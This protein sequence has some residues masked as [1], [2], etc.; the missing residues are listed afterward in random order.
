MK[1]FGT[2][3]I[4]LALSLSFTACSKKGQLQPDG[5]YN[6]E[7]GDVSDSEI[8]GGAADSDN[9][10]AMGLMTVFFPYDSAELVGEGKEAL[11]NNIRIMK[12]KSGLKVQIEGHCDERGGI[13]YNLALGERRA[14]ALKQAMVAGG[15]DS[16]RITTISM[17]KEKPLVPGSNEEAW[18]KNRRGN[19]A[20]TDK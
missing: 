18:A 4:A 14:N 7:G 11:K 12:E 10:N 17:G 6:G 8:A 5:G 15:V 1:F 3:C 9:G 19:F 2:L 13:Q 16:A 20:I